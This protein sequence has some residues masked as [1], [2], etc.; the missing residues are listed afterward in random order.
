MLHDLLYKASA[1]CSDV[2]D[3]LASCSQLLL[4]R[5]NTGVHTYFTLQRA[6]KTPEQKALHVAKGV[7]A[8]VRMESGWYSVPIQ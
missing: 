8:Q 6:D 4:F 1:S 7:V 3:M 2:L 5:M